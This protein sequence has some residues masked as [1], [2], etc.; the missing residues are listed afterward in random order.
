MR[1]SGQRFDA[2]R[3]RLETFGNRRHPAAGGLVGVDY[4]AVEQHF[5]YAVMSLDQPGPYAERIGNGFRQT[6]GRFEKASLHTVADVNR[7]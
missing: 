1:F 4:I 5:E 2:A 7:V 6:G 3:Q